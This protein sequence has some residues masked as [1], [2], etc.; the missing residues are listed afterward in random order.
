MVTL[1]TFTSSLDKS[2]GTFRYYGVTSKYYG[3][4]SVSRIDQI[5]GLFSK[6]VKETYNLI[7]L[8]TRSHP[9]L[10]VCLRG[11]L[12][13]QKI[14]SSFLTLF[15]QI[16]GKR[17][18]LIPLQTHGLIASGHLFVCAQSTHSET[19][20]HDKPFNHRTLT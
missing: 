12:I 18:F 10:A 19:L 7:D 5:I 16:V 2:R 14:L 8:T 6:R 15:L 20:S 4:T 3:V 11:A 13:C 9:I 1:L 17:R